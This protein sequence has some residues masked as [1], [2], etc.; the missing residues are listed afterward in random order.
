MNY[1]R[2]LLILGLL[3]I[4]VPFLGVPLLWKHIITVALGMLVIAFTIL[5]RSS[6]RAGK[7]PAIKQKS[8]PRMQRTRKIAIA[9]NR[10][11][12][13]AMVAETPVVP[14]ITS[15][16]LIDHDEA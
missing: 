14:T 2:A 16:S 6:M 11:L 15:E 13:D 1:P 8:A 5:L 12:S 7:Q 4:L 10:S 9:P 3:I